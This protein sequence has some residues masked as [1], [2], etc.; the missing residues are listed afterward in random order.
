M[1]RL[2]GGVTVRRH[3]RDPRFEEA[4]E[5]YAQQRPA[6]PDQQRPRHFADIGPLL[7]VWFN[8][9]VQV[10]ALRGEMETRRREEQRFW[11]G[12]H[13]V[14]ITGPQI[15]SAADAFVDQPNLTGPRRGWYWDIRR[16]T[17]TAGGQA[18]LAAVLVWKNAKTATNIVDFFAGQVYS[19]FYGKGQLLLGPDEHLIY[20]WPAG[21]SGPA[22]IA[23][24]GE[25][26]Q[27]ADYCLPRYLT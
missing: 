15:D 1:L 6:I 14:Q 8:L 13:R 12:I 18:G 20:G 3:G 7:D 17:F 24:A 26:I 5:R 2:N 11:A 19:H 25:A 16:L 22:D 21:A 10:D 23:V 27:V 9:G 4:G